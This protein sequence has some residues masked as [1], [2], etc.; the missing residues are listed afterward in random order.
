MLCC[1]RPVQSAAAAA[2]ALMAAFSRNSTLSQDPE[3][4]G[5]RGVEVVAGRYF[6]FLVEDVL[7]FQVLPAVFL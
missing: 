2:L 1:S 5:G 3:R 7:V 6:P 4:D